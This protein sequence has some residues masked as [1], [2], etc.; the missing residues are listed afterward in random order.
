MRTRTAA[1]SRLLHRKASFGVNTGACSWT[2]TRCYRPHGSLS[3]QKAPHT[4]SKKEEGSNGQGAVGEGAK[5]WKVLLITKCIRK[6]QHSI[7][8]SIEDL[9]LHRKMQLLHFDN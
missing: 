8:I 5:L 9:N 3:Q 7:Y 6:V 1:A 4:A 2:V